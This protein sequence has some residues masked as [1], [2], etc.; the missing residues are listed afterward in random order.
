MRDVR[1]MRYMRDVRVTRN[2]RFI[3][4]ARSIYIFMSDRYILDRFV[5]ASY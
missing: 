3:I 5:D 1:A 2:T 4:F